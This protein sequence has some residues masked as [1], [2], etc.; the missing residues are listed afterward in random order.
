MVAPSNWL[1][2]P[3][4]NACAASS[5]LIPCPF[6]ARSELIPLLSKFL[7]IPLLNPN[8]CFKPRF[9]VIPLPVPS[10]FRLVGMF[11]ETY[12]SR[13]SGSVSSRR[14][15]NSLPSYA[16]WAFCCS[17]SGVLA[18]L[19]IVARRSLGD[20]SFNADLL[21]SLYMLLSWPCK[22]FIFWTC[23]MAASSA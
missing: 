18:P 9:W 23:C 17:S 7:P 8:S 16:S 2:L 15:S 13:V 22:F 14:L 3:S 10:Q 11:C 6:G 20:I 19:R 5:T 12:S 1:G 4:H 21:R